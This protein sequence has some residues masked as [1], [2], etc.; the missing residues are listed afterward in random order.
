MKLNNQR[1]IAF[2]LVAF[3]ML[4][5]GVGVLKVVEHVDRTVINKAKYDA[6][7]VPNYRG[8]PGAPSSTRNWVPN[9]SEVIKDAN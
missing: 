8:E 5:S 1:G 9:N 4:M 2:A 3:W 6:G 7:L